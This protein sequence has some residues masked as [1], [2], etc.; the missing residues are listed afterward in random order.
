[1]YNTNKQGVA[2]KNLGYKRIVIEVPADLK[3]KL[4]EIVKLQKKTIKQYIISIIEK[5]IA[6]ETI[7]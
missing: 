6:S 7:N 2:M 4:D 5:E 1:L 3:I